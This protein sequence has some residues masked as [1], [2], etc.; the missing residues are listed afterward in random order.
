MW[1]AE[2]LWDNL[3][4]E[5]DSGSSWPLQKK[6]AIEE[7]KN[8]K[9]HCYTISSCTAVFI[10]LSLLAFFIPIFYNNLRRRTVTSLYNYCQ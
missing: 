7:Q 1:Q 9:Y 2:A 5:V 4:S 6:V 3:I 10:K 8:D